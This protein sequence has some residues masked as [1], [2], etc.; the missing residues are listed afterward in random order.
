MNV[1]RALVSWF[2]SSF[3]DEELPGRVTYTQAI[4]L[5]PVWYAVNKICGDIGQLPIDVKKAVGDGAENDLN[6]DGYRLLREQPNAIQS[7]SVFKEQV[8]GHALI[9]GNGR[10]AI[11]RNGDSIEELVPMMPD[12]TWTV[13]YK[14]QKY[15]VTRPLK[16]DNKEFFQLWE[17]DRNGYLVFHDDDVLH[18]PAFSYDGV[19]G[20]GLLDIAQDTL[21]IGNQSQ[22]HVR[23]QM[24]KGFRGKL[25]LEA[26]AQMFRQKGEAEKFIEE[27]N[28]SEAGADNAGKA[29]LLREGMK[30]QTAN[31]SNQEGQLVDLQKFNRQDV[32]LLFGIDRMPGDGESISHNSLEQQNLAYL[33]ALD[34]W[35]VKWEEQCD[36][37]LRTP[38]EKRLARRYFKFNRGAL[39]RT[40]LGTTMEAFSKGIASRIFNPNECR[41]KLDMNPYK[42]GEKYENPAIT[43]TEPA[44]QSQQGQSAQ[45]KAL[46]VTIRSLMQRE[47]NNAISGAKKK[48]FIGWID[49]NYPKWEA[50]LADKLEELGLDRDLASKHCEQSKSELL[51]VAGE[52]T[53]DNLEANVRRVVAGWVNRKFEV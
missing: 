37:K 12:R 42:G 21:G 29:A 45:A 35:L 41:S 39:L 50:K 1:F 40:D 4:G 49:E 25:F 38:S 53:E 43:P 51:A 2:N 26:P 11:V 48:N 20:L 31:S 46:D 32:G 27:F 9:W 28:A 18:I 30:I 23:N 8:T 44:Q 24:R 6:H 16:N 52:S 34:R 33:M 22:R 19:E 14:G 15:H 10:A 17:E 5:P 47:A 13:I 36:M 3:D 7:P